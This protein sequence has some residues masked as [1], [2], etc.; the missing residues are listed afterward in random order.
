MYF[1]KE[2]VTAKSESGRRSNWAFKFTK[3]E[4]LY[5]ICLHWGLQ[6]AQLYF[7]IE[8]QNFLLVFMSQNGQSPILI[9]FGLHFRYQTL[10]RQHLGD[11]SNPTHGACQGQRGPK[12]CGMAI[13]IST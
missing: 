1:S 10:M 5:Q 9:P 3:S 2:L 11:S 6:L 8:S 13:F 4:K 12:P 7:L